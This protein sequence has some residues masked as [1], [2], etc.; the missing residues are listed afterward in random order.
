MAA[1]DPELSYQRFRRWSSR[2]APPRSLHVERA[3]GGVALR[4]RHR[5]S[6]GVLSHRRDQPEEVLAFY[7]AHVGAGQPAGGARRADRG[8]D[9]QREVLARVTRLPRCARSR[10]GSRGGSSSPRAIQAALEYVFARWDGRGFPG[11]GGDAI[12]L[13]MRL[14]HVARDISLFL[15][16]AGPDEARGVLQRRTGTAY[17]PRLTELALQNLS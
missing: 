7:R 2:S 17:E 5:A 12:P 6:R 10:S 3:R 4:R 9:R 11:V 15:S 16:A 13:P 14:L 1:E 8:R